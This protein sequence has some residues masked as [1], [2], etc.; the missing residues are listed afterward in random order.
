MEEVIIDSLLSVAP[1]PNGSSKKQ[2]EQQCSSSCGLVG[3]AHVNATE[4]IDGRAVIS[5]SSAS[6]LSLQKEQVRV[7]QD[8]RSLCLDERLDT[9]GLRFAEFVLKAVAGFHALGRE[10]DLLL[11]QQN[12]SRPR[13][14]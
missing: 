11:A 13:N 3:V 1:S 5:M 14:L 8:E 12:S 2:D 10:L 4:E 9:E 7:E 6:V